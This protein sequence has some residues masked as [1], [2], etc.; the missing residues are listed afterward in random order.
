MGHVGGENQEYN[1]DYSSLITACSTE[2][3]GVNYKLKHK[4]QGKAQTPPGE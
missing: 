1:L 4:L 3:V 2:S